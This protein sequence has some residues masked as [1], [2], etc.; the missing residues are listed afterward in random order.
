MS[1]V[2][3]HIDFPYAGP[4]SDAMARAYADLAADIATEPGLLWKLWLENEATQR[5]GGA[6]LFAD[7]AQAERYLAKHRARLAEWGMHDLSVTVS[8]VNAALSAHTKATDSP[9]LPSAA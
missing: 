3:I 4:W 5:A 7:R 9:A 8:A 6:Y 1:A 2:L